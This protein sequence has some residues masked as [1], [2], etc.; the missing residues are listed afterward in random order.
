MKFHRRRFL[1]LA[2]VAAAIALLSVTVTGHR[3]WSQTARTIK[4][5]VAVQPGGGTDFLARVLG[6][7][8]GRA[9]GQT[10]LIE[11]RPGAGSIIGTE[12]VSHAAPDGN[13]L[14]IT[15]PTFV[16]NPH[17]RKVNYDPV[18]SFEP[19]CYL[20]N[21]PTVIVVNNASPYRTLANLLE[22]ARAKPGDLT[23]AGAG[24]FYLAVEMLKRA[25]NLNMTFVPYPGGAP[26]VTALLGEHVTSMF[27][28]YPTSAEQ[29]KAGKLRALATGSQ[30]RA[31]ALPDVPTVAESGY[32]DYDV[33]QWWGL[34]AP[35]KTPKETVSQLVGWFTAA[36]QVPEVKAKLV[37][38]GLY[39]VGI[40]GADFGAF[41]RKQY[42]DY[43]RAIREANIKAE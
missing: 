8:I 39:P 3:A 19:I 43:G 10:M 20:V 2:G 27:T 35:A 22:E 24:S 7:E 28:D 15:T 25:A 18:T 12:A 26:A 34:F 33:E 36:L 6:E 16:T 4:V 29:L 9:Q 42:D 37:A 14:L 23:M 1:H 11:N 21:A 13:T 31:E 30:T 5:V 32:K 40:C 38:Q 17:L 41:V